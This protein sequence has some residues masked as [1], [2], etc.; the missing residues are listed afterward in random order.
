MGYSFS[1]ASSLN[2]L[3]HKVV[4][5]GLKLTCN[6]SQAILG[7]RNRVMVLI[8][9]HIYSMTTS[10]CASCNNLAVR[11]RHSQFG[12]VSYRGADAKITFVVRT[13]ESQRS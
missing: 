8:R 5:S 6:N 11:Q 13:G 1:S 3:D 2:S 10:T 7:R 12:R 4:M 9:M